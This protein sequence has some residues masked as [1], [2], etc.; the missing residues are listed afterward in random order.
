MVNQIRT[1]LTNDLTPAGI[2]AM[3][4]VAQKAISDGQEILAQMQPIMAA[5]AQARAEISTG[6]AAGGGSSPGM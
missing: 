2:D 3:S 5:V 4:P 1:Y 6:A